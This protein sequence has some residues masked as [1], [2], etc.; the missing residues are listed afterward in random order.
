MVDFVIVGGKA[1][2]S[3]ARFGGESAWRNRKYDRSQERRYL[4]L[5]AK[6]LI[7]AELDDLDTYE[8][9]K[10]QVP[11]PKPE[12]EIR[13]KRQPYKRARDYNSEYRNSDYRSDSDYLNTPRSRPIFP[14]PIVH[15][16]RKVVAYSDGMR[17]Y[18][19]SY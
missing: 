12:T 17:I 8:P 11:A 16:N 19:A 14:R 9:V 13:K 2:K 4:K 6:A 15:N 7:A 1:R 5:I 18:S 10:S 3:K